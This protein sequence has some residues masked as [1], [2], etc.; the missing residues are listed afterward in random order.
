MRYDLGKNENHNTK[1]TYTR[2]HR[3]NKENWIFLYIWEEIKID[4]LF[5][6]K[7][8]TK[9]NKKKC[10]SIKKWK[11]FSC[12]TFLSPTMWN[13][14]KLVEHFTFFS[15]NLYKGNS[16]VVIIIFFALVFRLFFDKSFVSFY[17]FLFFV[18][19]L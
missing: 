11:L 3:N 5:T 4:N 8:E 6:K 13:V 18:C 16:Q 10:W 14:Y 19:I 2:I 7:M 1:H 15:V 12:V 9:I 17:I